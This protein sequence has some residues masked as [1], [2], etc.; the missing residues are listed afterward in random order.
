MYVC[1]SGFFGL[2]YIYRHRILVREITVASSTV[3]VVVIK[4]TCR[5]DE[6]LDVAC[7]T[8]SRSCPFDRQ[9]LCRLVLGEKNVAWLLQVCNQMCMNHIRQIKVTFTQLQ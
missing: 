7:L 6:V 3:A 1:M 8:T 2:P 4:S 9:T 5:H